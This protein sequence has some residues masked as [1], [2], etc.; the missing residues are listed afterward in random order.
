MFSCE[1]RSF[2]RGSTRIFKSVDGT[3]ANCDEI[4]TDAWYHF[5]GEDFLISFRSFKSNPFGAVI[6]WNQGIMFGLASQN[7]SW[8]TIQFLDTKESDVDGMELIKASSS[9]IHPWIFLQ[10]CKNI[11]ALGDKSVF[12][13]DPM[14]CNEIKI[15]GNNIWLIPSLKKALVKY[16]EPTAEESKA[17]VEPSEVVKPLV[18]CPPG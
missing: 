6:D 2:S 9:N 11:G 16:I 4:L 3:A 15:K 10:N 8:L 17:G 12:F 18:N 1:L 14:L 7:V 13:S 5:R